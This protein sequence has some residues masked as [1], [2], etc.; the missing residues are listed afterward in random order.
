MRRDGKAAAKPEFGHSACLINDGEVAGIAEKFRHVG[1]G[2]D[3]I[4]DGLA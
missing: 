2:R 3:S 4:E 1:D